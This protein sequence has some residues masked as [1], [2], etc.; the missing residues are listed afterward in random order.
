MSERK[1][2]LKAIYD[3]MQRA[4]EARVGRFLIGNRLNLAAPTVGTLPP[5]AGGTGGTSGV[6]IRGAS[7]YDNSV[8]PTSGQ[9]IV[10]NAAASKFHPAAMSGGSGLPWINV[11]DAAYGATG[12]G[13][14][15]DT[16][17]ISAAVS[18][19]NTAGGGVLYFPKGAYVTSGGFTITVPCIVQGDGPGS[20]DRTETVSKVICT[21]A[22]AVLFEVT[23]KYAKFRDLALICTAASP[24]AGSAIHANNATYLEARVDYDS[25]LVHGF[26][27][28]ID[29][30]V[31]A[32]WVMR[33]CQIIGPVR[34]GVHIRNTVNGDAGD[35]AISD[36]NINPALRSGG[37]GIYI[38]SS[39]GAK[40]TN[41]KVNA[42][43]P[44]DP[45]HFAYAIDVNW[46]VGTGV[47]L[48]GNSSIEAYTV[49]GLRM[50]GTT[51]DGIIIHGCEFGQQGSSTSP[52]IDISNM[53]DV[54]V[55]ACHFLTNSGSATAINLTSVTRAYIGAITNWN[56][57]QVVT[58]T[59]CTGV[60]D[61]SGGGSAPDATTTT[62]G[63]I[64]LAGD[65]AGTADSPALV[66]SGVAAGTYTNASVTVDAKGR[67]TSASSGSAVSNANTDA[68][69]AEID[70]LKARLAFY[71]RAGV[72]ASSDYSTVVDSSGNPVV[73]ADGDSVTAGV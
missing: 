17:A 12:N 65:L 15:D 25:L 40:I 42:D 68:V 18:A 10:W 55:D 20:F 37:T 54:I 62:K 3:E 61:L 21:S 44:A 41:L 70:Y 6:T 69:Q 7:D 52:A 57:T 8:A 39:G 47:F 71:D 58:Q 32:Q 46:T 35:W 23:S 73:T 38:E 60:I 72:V 63:S 28:C 2:L 56:F 19:L 26:Y 5:T 64:R 50:Q 45:Q 9:A 51:V 24:T 66:T 16:A 11:K 43:E 14:T 22:T 36:C 29:V 4:I 48:L 34:Y 59:S 1:L 33:G 13:V 53:Q 31:G 30:Q 67:V 49:S 27:D